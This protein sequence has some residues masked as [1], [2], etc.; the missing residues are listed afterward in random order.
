MFTGNVTLAQALATPLTSRC[1]GAGKYTR[2]IPQADTARA[3]LDILAADGY[4]PHV[5]AAAVNGRYRLALAI[6][7]DIDAVHGPMRVAGHR[8]M[9]LYLSE[10]AQNRSR[11][12]SGLTF[13]D[14]VGYA[15]GTGNYRRK[16]TW[17]MSARDVAQ[18][19]IDRYLD[20]AHDIDAHMRRMREDVISPSRAA[21]MVCGLLRP[22]K[23]FPSHCARPVVLAMDAL[24]PRNALNVM[25][26][27]ARYCRCLTSVN[28]IMYQ[29]MLC[30][31]IHSHRR[32]KK[33]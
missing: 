33:T 11:V 29:S 32:Y 4:K 3:V 8:C 21:Q 19:M 1:K 16:M 30:D 18:S 28:Q 22:V 13:D 5:L 15:V 25:E 12:V 24:K 9:G 17:T 6:R 31:L 20:H 2:P 23:S 27:F 14:D 26:S 10:D 7:V